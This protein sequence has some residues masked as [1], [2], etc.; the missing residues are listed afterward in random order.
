LKIYLPAC[1]NQDCT[2]NFTLSQFGPFLVLR[3]CSWLA[4]T[5]SGWIAC[6]LVRLR[7]GLLVGL[8]FGF[9]LARLLAF[10]FLAC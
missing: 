6:L 8:P 1:N 3:L 10:W 7:A 4:C 2:E 9:L 5:L